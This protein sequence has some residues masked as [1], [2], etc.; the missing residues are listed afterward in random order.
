MIGIQATQPVSFAAWAV[1]LAVLVGSGVAAGVWLSTRP[2]IAQNTAYHDFAD[3]RT[4]LGVPHF[5]NVASNAPFLVLGLA[6]LWYY[7]LGARSRGGAAFTYAVERLP[8][9]LL[10]LGVLLTAFGSA[11]YH[12]HPNNEHLVWDRLPMAL[13]FTA[14]CSGLLIERVGLR[15]GLIAF[16]VLIAAGVGSVLY[17]QQTGDLRPY[18][19]VQF[20]R[21]PASRYCWCSFRLNTRGPFTCCSPCSGMSWPRSANTLSTNRSM[22][23]ATC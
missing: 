10:F 8:Y 15:L 3:Q 16:P 14:L 2:P 19:F 11:Y 4:L 21:W 17:W 1:R 7:A 13:G 22:V 20:F 18:Y 23:L 5:W 6:G 9:L 12:L